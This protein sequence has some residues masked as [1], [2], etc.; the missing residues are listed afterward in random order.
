MKV[1][2]PVSRSP[3]INA[4]FIGAAPRYCGN[5]EACRLN[6][7][8]RGSSNT[9]RGSILNATDNPEVGTQGSKFRDEFLSLE[10]C[11]LK[12]WQTGGY[13]ITF[14]GTLLQFQSPTS[15]FVGHGN[16]RHY[17]I[18]PLHQRLQGRD[19]EV[20]RSHIHDTQGFRIGCHTGISGSVSLLLEKTE[21]VPHPFLLGLEV[22]LVVFRRFGHDRHYLF[23][24]ESVSFESGTLGGIVGHQTHFG[25]AERMQDAGTHTVIPLVHG[26]TELQVASAV[27]YPF[28]SCNL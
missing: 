6:V 1:V 26:K 3:L 28:S 27:S 13:G 8:Y 23:D 5:R 2:T 17:M 14:Y 25:N 7:P 4:Q 16:N 19:G 21:L 11:R 20:G 9:A 18:A 24:G 15:R 22:T 10:V 12:E